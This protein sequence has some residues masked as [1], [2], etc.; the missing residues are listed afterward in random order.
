[1]IRYREYW[2]AFFDIAREPAVGEV[3]TLDDLLEVPFIKER[4]ERPGGEV[5]FALSLHDTHGH[6]MRCT[7][8]DKWW[9][10][11]TF[12]YDTKPEPTDKLPLWVAPD[13]VQVAPYVEKEYPDP[14]PLDDLLAS[15]AVTKTVR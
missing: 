11:A 8:D 14:V 4:T 15:G 5:K 7:S 3:E 2:P 12:F 1:M 9:V 6:L 13:V 10:V